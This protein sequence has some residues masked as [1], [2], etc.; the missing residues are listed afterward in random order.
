MFGRIMLKLTALQMIMMTNITTLILFTD[1][2]VNSNII[3]LLMVIYS[4][5]K[6]KSLMLNL[7]R[8]R[9][10]YKITNSYFLIVNLYM[11]KFLLL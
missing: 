3:L 1:K 11:F 4:F 9:L 5:L 7:L 6:N 8:G 10:F 2:H